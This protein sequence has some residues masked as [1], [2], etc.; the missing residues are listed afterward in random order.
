MM[1][2]WAKHYHSKYQSDN[3]FYELNQLLMHNR[4][5]YSLN[6]ISDETMFRQFE[7]IFNREACNNENVDETFLRQT[8]D[9]YSVKILLGPSGSDSTFMENVMK[10]QMKCKG[11]ERIKFFDLINRDSFNDFGFEGIAKRRTKYELSELQKH[12]M[13]E[14]FADKQPDEQG[15]SL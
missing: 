6:I 7:M 3:Q 10:V 13:L 9:L 1:S 4:K 2:Y 14:H 12:T 8:L 15:T 11:L 5:Q